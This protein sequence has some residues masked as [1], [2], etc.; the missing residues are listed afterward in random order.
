MA[1]YHLKLTPDVVHRASLGSM[2]TSTVAGVSKQRG[3]YYESH[4]STLAAAEWK[5]VMGV[6][7]TTFTNTIP[8]WSSHANVVAE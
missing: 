2:D 6:D 3:G 4:T 7:G 5:T 1:N 8:T